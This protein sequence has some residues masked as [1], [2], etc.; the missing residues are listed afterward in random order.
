MLSLA[1]ATDFSGPANDRPRAAAAAARA[2]H[3]GNLRI[4]TAVPLE[5]VKA[6]LQQVETLELGRSIGRQHLR[7]H[8][9]LERKLVVAQIEMLQRGPAAGLYCTED[10]V[11]VDLSGAAISM[12]AAHVVDGLVGTRW[13]QARKYVS[14]SASNLKRLR[15]RLK[16]RLANVLEKPGTVSVRLPA[17]AVQ[18]L[19][20]QRPSR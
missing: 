10:E 18:V 7:E 2:L 5:M 8:A 3:L 12:C 13:Q 20:R 16:P 14:A 1:T 11:T 17:G 6:G 4:G 19:E 9:R 15:V